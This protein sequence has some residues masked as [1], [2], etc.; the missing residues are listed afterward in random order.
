[1]A[2][3]LITDN[4]LH[5]ME[6][7]SFH[8]ESN[9]YPISYYCDKRRSIHS[10]LSST[11]TSTANSNNTNMITTTEASPEAKRFAIELAISELRELVNRSPSISIDDESGSLLIMDLFNEG[12]NTSVG[13]QT[14]LTQANGYNIDDGIMTAPNGTQIFP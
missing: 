14:N 8:E 13:V 12:N 7:R 5:Q 6:R 3:R 9:C 4:L 10:S 2:T 11:S 1:M